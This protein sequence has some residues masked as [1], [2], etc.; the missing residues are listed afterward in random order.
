MFSTMF[1][2]FGVVGGLSIISCKLLSTIQIDTELSMPIGN[3]AHGVVCEL[4]WASDQAMTVEVGW[5]FQLKNYRIFY[6]E[7]LNYHRHYAKLS[8]II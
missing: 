1:Y 5:T 2:F 8:V 6:L 7:V 3:R 4:L